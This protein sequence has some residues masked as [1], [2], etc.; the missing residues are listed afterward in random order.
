V[1]RRFWRNEDIEA[2]AQ[3]RLDELAA[4]LGKAL[5]PP[6]PLELLAEQ[7]LGLD[8]LWDAIDELPGEVILAGLKA[9]DRLV[10]LNENRKAKFAEHA[11]LERFTVGHEFGHWDLYTDH[12]TLDH[13]SLF[14][15]D[16]GPVVYRSTPSGKLV[17]VLKILRDVEEGRELLQAFAAR[18]D[19]PDEAR[20]VNRYSSAILMPK[21]L[22]RSEAARIDRT[23]WH[24]LYRLAERFAVSITALTVRLEQLDLLVIDRKSG[25]LHP[26]REAATGQ[27]SLF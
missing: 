17:A 2:R 26:S 21:D 12:A 8:F 7:V 3:G 23:N 27:R 15:E 10:I 22:I 9:K 25:R 18:A 20:A 13:P 19:D 4:K 14:A 1:K 16:G 5:T 6:I 11:G 24:Q